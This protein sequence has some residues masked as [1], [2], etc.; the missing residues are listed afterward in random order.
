MLNQGKR[1]G[2][3]ILNALPSGTVTAPDPAGAPASGSCAQGA[4]KHRLAPRLVLGQE[5]GSLAV[6]F[7]AYSSTEL[8]VTEIASRE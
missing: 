3:Q 8:V 5:A 7:T 1:Q 2:K 4:T 6:K